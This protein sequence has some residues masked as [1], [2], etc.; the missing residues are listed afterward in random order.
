MYYKFG[1]LR[2]GAK[3]VAKATKTSHF[4]KKTIIE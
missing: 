2:R 1:Q 4:E 3:F